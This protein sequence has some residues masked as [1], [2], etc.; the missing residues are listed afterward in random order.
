MITNTSLA[1]AE[2]DHQRCLGAALSQA[3]HLC[4]SHN[5]KLTPLRES[6]L[7]IIWQSHKPIGAYQIIQLL[8]RQQDKQV[9][10]PTV[11]RTL[12]F[13][14]GQ[15][16]IH[17]INSLNAFIGCPFPNAEHSNMF[18]L[19]KSCGSVAECSTLAVDRAISETAA[20]SGFNIDAHSIEVLGLCPQCS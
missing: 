5:T 7:R 14:L 6:V 19:C 3:Q 10:P 9:M 8:S 20:R 18:M 13:L 2:H 12:D 1:Y 16:L 17:R 15:G 4:E 11:Y